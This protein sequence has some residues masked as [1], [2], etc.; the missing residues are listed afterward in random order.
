MSEPKNPT[1]P[2]SANRGPGTAKQELRQH[3]LIEKVLPDPSQLASLTTLSGFIGR[4]LQ[5]GYWRLYLT[6]TLDEYVEIREDDI[7]HT[8]TLEPSQSALGR[9][10]VWLRSGVTLQYTRFTSRQIQ[11]EFLQG[12][13]ATGVRASALRFQPPMTS[14]RGANPRTYIC[15]D[16]YCG[17]DFCSTD[18]PR[19]CHTYWG[20]ACG[21]GG[22]ECGWSEVV[23]A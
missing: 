21:T 13:L 22:A 9:T 3:E 16:V 10:V 1:D 17:S 18:V 8:Q 19:Y 6:P 14:Q 12:P 11:A 7:V 5:E 23:C 4:S 20:P 15:S 2:A